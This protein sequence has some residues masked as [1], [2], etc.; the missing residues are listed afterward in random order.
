YTPKDKDGNPLTP[1]DPE[2]KT[3]GYVP[4]SIVNPQDPTEDTPVPYEKNPVGTVTAKFVDETGAEV[5]ASEPVVE[6]AEVGTD[7]NATDNGV[8]TIDK[9]GVTYYLKETPAN[10]QGKVTTEETVVT[11]VYKKSGSYVPQ[12]QGDEPN[13]PANPDKV[14]YDKTPEEPSDNP[15]LPYVPG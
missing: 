13:K 11:F 10:V 14:P 4:P 12:I 5:K 15:A 7:Y 6:N 1:V 3:K 2:D 8:K 9:D